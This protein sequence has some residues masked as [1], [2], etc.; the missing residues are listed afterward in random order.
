MFHIIFLIVLCFLWILFAVIQDLRTR[1]IANWLNF[2]LIIF[3][4]GFRFFYGLFFDIN[5]G[6]F[7]QGLIGLGVFFILGNLFYY[8]HIFAGGDAKLMIALGAILPFSKSF[9]IN[10]KLFILFFIL[11]LVSGMIY[12]LIFS[13]TLMVKHWASFK[14]EFFKQLKIFKKVVI[15]ILVIGLVFMSLG[16][17][18]SLFFCLGVFVFLLPYLFIFSKS[19]D[20]VCMVKKI[21]SKFLREGDWLYKDVVVGGKKIKAKWEGISR[22]DIKLLQKNKIVT[23]RHGIAFAPVFLISFILLVLFFYFG[24]LDFFDLLFLF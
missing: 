8:G 2:S 14:K 19:I 12:G 9:L 3:A 20:E 13:L 23:I 21:N 7:Y 16:F 4:L 1:E 24:A 17:F 6:F 5:Y 11:F 18:K 15:L 22:E 10:I